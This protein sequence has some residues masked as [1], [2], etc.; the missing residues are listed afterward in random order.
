VQHKN[1]QRFPA[2]AA[3]VRLQYATLRHA[4]LQHATYDMISCARSE[5]APARRGMLDRAQCDTQHGTWHTP[6]NMAS[7]WIARP[8][9]HGTTVHC[10]ASW[11]GASSR[12]RRSTSGTT[13]RDRRR[14]R[15]SGAGGGMWRTACR[16]RGSRHCWS[17]SC[18]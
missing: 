8:V 1:V 4:T 11:R 16:K 6:C 18:A 14:T 7:E 9:L 15:S 5:C 17:R 10:A 3:N 13:G 2:Y 12:V